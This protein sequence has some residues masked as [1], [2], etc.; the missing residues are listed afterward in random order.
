MVQGAACR[1]MLSMT[2]VG[3]QACNVVVDCPCTTTILLGIHFF[4][5]DAHRYV[6]MMMMMMM[7]TLQPFIARI[8]ACAC[9]RHLGP[10]IVLGAEL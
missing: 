9:C 5:H 1:A 8:L 6:M 2:S 7:M 4:Q 3:K 10:M